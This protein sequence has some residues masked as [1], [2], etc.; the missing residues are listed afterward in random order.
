[1]R[2]QQPDDFT[3][4]ADG[5]R[6][7]QRGGEVQSGR[8]WIHGESDSFAYEVIDGNGGSGHGDGDDHGGGQQCA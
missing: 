1:M 2:S 8:Q 4:N 7:E 6:P 3:A 5:V